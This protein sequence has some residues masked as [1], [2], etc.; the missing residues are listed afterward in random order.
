MLQLAT[1]R[2]LCALI[3]LCKLEKMPNELRVRFI[4]EIFQGK[5]CSFK[6][7]N[8]YK[9]LQ[10]ILK[11]KTILKV[12]ISPHQ[13]AKKL[14]QDYRFEVK[15]TL[16]LV[17][18]AKKCQYKSTGLGSLAQEVLNVKLPLK[19]RGLIVDKMHR[20]WENDTLNGENIKYA[21]N[22]VHASIELF[23]KFEGKLATKAH[24]TDD[25]Q[26]KNLQ[27]FIYQHCTPFI[28]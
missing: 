21:A 22:D 6:L 25:N 14:A 27:D 26:T 16:D 7:S 4:I 23:K 20:N 8:F 9:S 12:G 3:R 1:N 10:E 11:D 17:R 5:F 18:L 15:G 2:G 19:K 28:K 13:D 24:G